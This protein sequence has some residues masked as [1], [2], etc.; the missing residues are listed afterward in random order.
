MN[1]VSNLHPQ[2]EPLD[3]NP[4]IPSSLVL[5][6]NQVLSS[7]QS[8]LYRRKIVIATVQLLW[9]KHLDDWLFASVAMP[10][11]LNYL[12]HFYHITKLGVGIKGGLEA[13][14]HTTR[15]LINHF[16]DVD[17]MCILKVD[18]RNAF[19]ECQRQKFLTCIATQFWL[20]AILLLPACKTQI[21]KP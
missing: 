21:W 7:L 20:G 16:Q 19:N 9:V 4:S 10:Y 5:D 1:N 17:N 2:S 8:W 15:Y 14:I 18:F 13:T 3:F 11:V 6:C 12:K